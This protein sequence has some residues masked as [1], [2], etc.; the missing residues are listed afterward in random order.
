MNRYPSDIAL[1]P[2]VA[3]P[4]PKLLGKAI[5]IVVIL[6]VAFAVGLVPRLRRQQAGVAPAGA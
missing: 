5:V 1:E 3:P 4:R 2:A 6:I